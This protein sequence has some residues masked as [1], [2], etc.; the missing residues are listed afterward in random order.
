MKRSKF[1]SRLLSGLLAVTVLMSA[2]LST[3]L[4]AFATSGGH[5]GAGTALGGGGKYA[6]N[7]SEGVLKITAS[8]I[9]D[10]S[11]MA[12]MADLR[13]RYGDMI[14]FPL[15]LQTGGYN[16]GHYGSKIKQLSNGHY[17]YDV[18]DVSKW[19]TDAIDEYIKSEAD[20]S[21]VKN[22]AT[23]RQNRQ[24]ELRS[25]KNIVRYDVADDISC[26]SSTIYLEDCIRVLDSN[27]NKS[28]ISNF[29]R[30]CFWY[31]YTRIVLGEMEDG[32]VYDGVDSNL[33]NR[34]R[35][36]ITERS[37]GLGN[38]TYHEKAMQRGYLVALRLVYGND[39][40]QEL[41]GQKFSTATSFDSVLTWAN[42]DGYKSI[43]VDRMEN[44]K[45]LDSLTVR[46]RHGNS[47]TVSGLYVGLTVHDFLDLYANFRGWDASTNTLRENYVW[48]THSFGGGSGTPGWVAGYDDV[49]SGKVMGYRQLLEWIYPEKESGD[50]R[51]LYYGDTSVRAFGG[52]GYYPFKEAPE[53][54]KEPVKYPTLY[55]E[56]IQNIGTSIVYN[57]YLSGGSDF[58]KEKSD[59]GELSHV[60]TDLVYISSP[61]D[62]SKL[63]EENRDNVPDIVDSRNYM[64]S[65]IDTEISLST[66]VVNTPYN[67]KRVM[68]R[69][70]NA[71][72]GSSTWVSGSSGSY[73]ETALTSD[74]W[75]TENSSDTNYK[76]ST[77]IPNTSVKS[78]YIGIKGADIN[79]ALG[80]EKATVKYRKETVLSDRSLEQLGY[81]NVNMDLGD[82][83]SN[84]FY[85]KVYT[86]DGSKYNVVK[87]GNEEYNTKTFAKAYP[88][89]VKSPNGTYSL[90]DGNPQSKN[91]YYI[92][93]NKGDNTYY[94]ALCVYGRWKFY[95]LSSVTNI[96]V[97]IRA[98]YVA[99]V[100]PGSTLYNN[101][102]QT[103]DIE[104]YLLGK[105]L[106]TDDFT[107]EQVWTMVDD[108]ST[109]EFG[110]LS[111][112]NY[113][114]QQVIDNVL[115]SYNIDEYMSKKLGGDK[116]EY[117]DINGKRIN[118]REYTSANGAMLVNEESVGV[119]K[120]FSWISG[121]ERMMRYIE[122]LYKYTPYISTNGVGDRLSA[123]METTLRHYVNGSIVSDDRLKQCLMAFTKQEDSNSTV[124]KSI[125]GTQNNVYYRSG[126]SS[127]WYPAEGF[128]DSNIDLGGVVSK[129]S[130][131]NAFQYWYSTDYNQE[132][133]LNTEEV[134]GY[135]E[136]YFAKL[137]V[138]YRKYIYSKRSSVAQ[139]LTPKR[140][141]W[142]NTR[143]NQ[144]AGNAFGLVDGSKGTVLGTEKSIDNGFIRFGKVNIGGT[145]S[146]IPIYNNWGIEPDVATVGATTGLAL[147]VGNVNVHKVVDI[148]QPITQSA[149]DIPIMYKV[150][151]HVPEERATVSVG[152]TSTNPTVSYG[153]S[154]IGVGHGTSTTII[155][156]VSALTE[157]RADT[158]PIKV[159]PE[160]DMWGEID[161]SADLDENPD[162]SIEYA[163]VTTV[164][165]LER[166]LPNITYSALTIESNPQ[167]PKVAGTA[168]AF[169]TRAKALA[170]R[171]GSPDAIVLY[172]GT[173]LNIAYSA[174]TG[175]VRTYVLGVSEDYKAG[176]SSTSQPLGSAWGNEDT[177]AVA[178]RAM[179]SFVS[180]FEAVSQPKMSIVNNSVK[181]FD[182]ASSTTDL[183]LTGTPEIESTRYNLTVK[184]GVL[185]TVKA[186][187]GT[188]ISTYTVSNGGSNSAV[189]TK[190]DTYGGTLTASQLREVLM[191]MR[192]IGANNVLS[193][194]FEANTG[195]AIDNK[196][197]GAL[198]GDANARYRTGGWYYEDCS[199]LTI[200]VYDG[201]FEVGAGTATEQ[202]PITLGP[203]TPSDK[204]KYF[205]QGFRGYIDVSTK[206]RYKD[207]AVW[208][209]TVEFS[210]NRAENCATEPADFIVSDVTINE[211]TT[212]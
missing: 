110:T 51:Q 178:V 205:S 107:K 22:N 59:F 63:Y 132:A 154:V 83:E 119:S 157:T 65:T 52:W 29:D 4:T 33:G 199:V 129:A 162:T 95:P 74:R 194:A 212:Y 45:L 66:P 128:L 20:S 198:T 5:G 197:K 88:T 159:Y 177:S 140:A 120:K 145:S 12:E 175:K 9:D 180:G 24:Y 172:S 61:Q 158:K 188:V 75:Y 165:Q 149:I 96:L 73:Y 43:V 30:S 46:D 210:T 14:D 42:S 68:Y 86:Y 135:K 150:T 99:S 176:T 69:I 137:L 185:T 27:R 200:K 146:I 171:L 118:S 31:F 80:Q 36:V 103:K 37:N 123:N 87:N 183:Q 23:L 91:F 109:D 54:S 62:I 211:A 21:V 116:S 49:Y 93:L 94:P 134:Y 148:A 144:N 138:G 195:G 3:A 104:P 189:V 6:I 136:A 35:E 209:K 92:Q 32:C 204:N 122:Y 28:I 1:G 125:L 113:I 19:G 130:G 117:E 40:V 155:D 34:L 184:G 181:S 164:G 187:N 53:P 208:N 182:L 13:N 57:A 78:A 142:I 47:S 169:D 207:T 8:K 84:R 170:Q 151:N 77:L 167:K 10:D 105:N 193:Q 70:T 79:D 161:K 97:Q 186:Y 15:Y 100:S 143:S 44:L 64:R 56:D 72:G 106:S 102:Y 2:G 192:L 41:T 7:P 11:T 160:V 112:R 108:F 50:N 163:T 127:Y 168:T 201:T 153:G 203:A 115:K 196:L 114:T 131:N 60:M 206:V 141:V 179:N 71:N 133:L 76:L 202:I 156:G 38:Q 55:K 18:L 174:T 191:K 121:Q 190:S 111:R 126:Y 16:F 98:D 147:G 25:A 89:G 173:G 48:Q 39:A 58:N 90:T 139:S 81:Y 85:Y 26:V 17:R 152:G 67:L 166:Q 101:V 124:A 82:I